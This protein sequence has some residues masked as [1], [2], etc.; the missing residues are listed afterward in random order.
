M[1]RIVK[2]KESDKIYKYLD[3]ARELKNAE[4]HEGNCDIHCSWSTKRLEELEIR[5]RIDTIQIKKI[6]EIGQNS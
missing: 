6:I 2:I 3:L 1:D 5:G 4:E